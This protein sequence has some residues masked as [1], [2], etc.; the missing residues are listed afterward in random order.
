MILQWLPEPSS[1]GGWNEKRCQGFDR[2]GNERAEV[3]FREHFYQDSE[4]VIEIRG[5]GELTRPSKLEAQLYAESL[6]EE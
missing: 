6:I 4:W 5:K 2:F 1:Q 3:S